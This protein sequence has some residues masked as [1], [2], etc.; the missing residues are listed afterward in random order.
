MPQYHGHHVILY[1]NSALPF[2]PVSGIGKVGK[3]RALIVPYTS[4]LYIR[5]VERLGKCYLP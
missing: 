4:I 2:Y 5:N 1:L 3:K